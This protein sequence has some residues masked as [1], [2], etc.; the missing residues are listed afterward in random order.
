M[1]DNITS[2]YQVILASQSPRRQQLIK[3]ILPE[4]KIEVREIDEIYPDHLKNEEIAMYLSKLKSDA[5]DD[6][7][8]DQLVITAD[9]I[10]CLNDQVLGKPVD[11]SHAYKMLTELSGNTHTVYSGVTI[12]T[13]DK[14]ITFY[15]ATHVTF[16]PLSSEEIWNYIKTCQPMD[17]AGA[18]GI[19]EW[20]GYVGI[21]KMEGEFYNVMGLPLH[22]VYRELRQF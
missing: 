22:R 17:K 1:L 3:E 7:M 19:Q 14:I 2:K 21:Q 18:Y 4:F 5:F 15:D 9:T 8:E 13:V 6:L 16:Y 11:E 20:M 12:K 10:V